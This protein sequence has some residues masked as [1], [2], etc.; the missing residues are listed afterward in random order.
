MTGAPPPVATGSTPDAGP[1]PELRRSA[2]SGAVGLAGAAA[3]GAFGFLLA[4]VITRGFGTA[5]AGALFTA[6][7]LLTVAGAVCCLGADT[8]LVWAL[9]RR[10]VRPGGD[11][12]RLLPVALVP[13]LL[14]AGALA[15]GGILAADRL[16]PV[17]LDGAGPDGVRL[18]RLAFA[19]VPLVVATTILL[20]AVRAVRPIAAYVGVQF[21]L[22]PVG[23]PLLVA[24]AAL[25]GAGTVAALAGWA[26]PLVAAVLAGAALVRGPLGVGTGTPLRP[27]RADWSTFW[28]FALPRAASAV[29]DSGGMWFGVLLTAAL[30]GPAEAGVFGAVGR[31]V[32]AGQLA[33]HGLRVAVAPQL[34][35]L[36]GAGLRDRAGAVHRQTTTWAVL[37]SWPVYLLLAAFA[38]GFLLLFGPGFTA[39]AAAL[40]VLSAAMLVNVGLGNV[41]TL[42]LMGGHSGRHLAAT[43]LG[44]ATTGL[45][46]VLLVPAHGALGAAIGWAA[47]IVVENVVAAV[48]AVP[49]LGRFPVD[50]AVTG[51]AVGV[52]A[53]VGAAALVGGLVAGRGLAGLAV[54]L[55]LLA[56][57]AGGALTRP[58]VRRRMAGAVATLRGGTT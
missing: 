48:A 54:A 40:A 39:G 38:P 18:L 20:A 52:A 34:S 47:G 26:L 28:R 56:A 4:V 3:S 50:A 31:Y 33:L 13:P 19:A 2:R 25:V 21:L 35:R 46:G 36:L 58:A 53:A 1:A 16:A 22:L 5:G 7:G 45:L 51:A 9:P 41:Q 55:G 37:L 12:A 32:L 49:V 24:A 23:R 17:L 29:I 57:G 6:I 42:L 27:A 14:A 44:L 8:G 10:G 30:A 43:A 11:A 15:L